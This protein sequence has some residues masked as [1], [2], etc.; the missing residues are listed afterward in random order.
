[1]LADIASVGF[2]VENF[3]R[4]N[5]E[6]LEHDW[7]AIR[8][9]LLMTVRVAASF[10]LSAQ[11]RWAESSLLP[12]AYY[13]YRRETPE[14]Y[15][16]HTSH[17]VDRRNIRGWLIP[18]LPKAS[19]IWGS[20]LDTLL[21][22]LRGVIQREGSAAFPADALR[23][24]LVQRG[25]S[26]AFGPEELEELLELS[27]GD[28]R[29][30]LVLSLLYPFVD[31][32]NQFHID[33]VFPSSRLTVSRLRRDGVS[34]AGIPKYVDCANRLANLQLLDGPTNNES[35]R[36][37]RPLGLRKRAATR[38]PRSTIGAGMI[39]E[40]C[41]RQLVIFLHSTT[42]DV[43]D[44]AAGLASCSTVDQRLAIRKSQ[45]SFA[46]GR[47]RKLTTPRPQATGTPGEPR[48]VGRCI[49]L[50]IIGS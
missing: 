20:G 14:N 9:T 48:V 35:E 46:S 23:A 5:M 25:K 16:T 40:P 26:L 2:K 8:R 24:V 22:A 44:S 43:S 49:P 39:L 3:T 45:A 12:I 21:T 28:R 50:L 42:Q 17:E 38:S 6:R 1:M 37:S 7:E 36:C 29:A 4:A 10:G 11:G 13:L 19:G 34:D 18:S 47:L 32:R 30:F 33:H 27:Y 15:L 31:L 41:P